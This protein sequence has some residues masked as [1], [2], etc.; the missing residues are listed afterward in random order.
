M[1]K[2]TYYE[3]GISPHMPNLT[4]A[5]EQGISNGTGLL[6]LL[7]LYGNLGTTFQQT[8]FSKGSYMPVW[9][10]QL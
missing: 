1:Y 2:K 5:W 10:L 9:A 4:I 3:I 7:D 6:K 8:S